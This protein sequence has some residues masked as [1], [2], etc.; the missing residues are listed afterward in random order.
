MEY[1][2]LIFICP[3]RIDFYCLIF[4]IKV[5]LCFHLVCPSFSTVEYI[6]PSHAEVCMCVFMCVGGMRKGC[7][8]R[9][10]EFYCASGSSLCNAKCYLM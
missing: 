7:K 9:Q 6:S 3:G 4:N 1:N 10:G 5:K 8:R 2:A